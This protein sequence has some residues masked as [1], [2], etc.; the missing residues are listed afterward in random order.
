MYFA[1]GS[2]VDGWL[3]CEVVTYFR[4][5]QL[6]TSR[7][8]LQWLQVLVLHNYISDKKSFSACGKS[9]YLLGDLH[10][11][12]QPTALS[13]FKIC[14]KKSGQKILN[15]KNTKHNRTQLHVPYTAIP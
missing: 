15:S 14:G 7:Y 13:L 4:I 10:L 8:I 3:S 9:G 5:T 11:I 2:T 1:L 6:L 12:S